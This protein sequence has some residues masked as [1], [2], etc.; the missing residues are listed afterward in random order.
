ML[1]YLYPSHDGIHMQCVSFRKV[2]RSGVRLKVL[3]FSLNGGREPIYNTESVSQAN[4]FVG[5]N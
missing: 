3:V 1:K 5:D 4:D 2:G